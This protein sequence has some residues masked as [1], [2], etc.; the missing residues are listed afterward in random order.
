MR[1]VLW[2]TYLAMSIYNKHN[3]GANDTRSSSNLHACLLLLLLQRLSLDSLSHMNIEA[4][5]KLGALSNARA[6]LVEDER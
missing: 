5:R 3:R 1:G 6:I 2:V 4:R